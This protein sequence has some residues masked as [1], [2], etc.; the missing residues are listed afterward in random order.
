VSC[1]PDMKDFEFRLPDIGEGLAE[2]EVVQW[3]VSVGDSV[4]ENQ[5]IVEIETDKAIVEFP[6]PAT[7]VVKLLPVA[8]GQ[9]VK[10]GDVLVVLSVSGTPTAKVEPA[11]TTAAVS[12]A[13]SQPITSSTAAAP[14][15][16]P[17]VRKLAAELG[18]S[19]SDV[20]GTGP[21]GRIL[22]GDIRA[23]A[24]AGQTMK[25]KT[26]ASSADSERIP[27]RG[28]RR[29]IAEA[30]T[31]TARTI[32]HVCGFHELDAVALSDAYTRLKQKAAQEIRLTYLAFIVKAVAL[33]LRDHPY[34]NA[35]YDEEE[36]AIVLHKR[37]NIGIATATAE[38]LVVPVIHDA[39]TLSLF[40]IAR[41]VARLSEAARNRSVRPSDL[42]HS[43]F[44]ITNVGAAGGW[45]GTSLVHY[46]E[47][48][49]LGL[50]KIEER[51]V[52]RNG[53][54]VARAILPVSLTFDHR[55]VDGD[56]ALAFM[57]TLR[58]LLESEKSP[59]LSGS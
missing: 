8:P 20:R 7:G 56:A 28:L 55:L 54:I 48:G 26:K 53:K 38:G 14:Q 51:A 30:M 2:A 9:R 3:R 6:S 11:S 47:A 15:A 49:I 41:A 12:A 16:A 29:R 10:V 43:T 40:E 4:Q 24:V 13:I 36:P 17:A 59:V 19:L 27:V 44:T 42:Q 57:R 39:D 5:T 1:K 32:P 58:G 33:A 37:R 23:H 46:P 22:P 21:N 50:G 25:T 35:E 52:V 31:H 18:V 45:F 34:L